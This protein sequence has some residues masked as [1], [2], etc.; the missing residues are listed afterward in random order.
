MIEIY[1]REIFQKTK[2]IFDETVKLTYETNFDD[3]IYYFKVL[4]KD[5][6]NFLKK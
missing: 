5:F 3:L 6:T 1:H 4:A 2:I